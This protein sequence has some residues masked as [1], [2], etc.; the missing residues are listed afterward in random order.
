MK[1]LQHECGGVRVKQTPMT[2]EKLEIRE[3]KKCNV[4]LALEMGMEMEM[5]MEILKRLPFC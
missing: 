2:P 1:Q 5:E 4:R 3:L